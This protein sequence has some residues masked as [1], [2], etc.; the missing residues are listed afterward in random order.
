MR[1]TTREIDHSE[2]DRL[3]VAHVG[4]VK[5]LAHRLAQRLPP[6]VEIPDLISIGVLGLMDAAGRY[7]AVARRAVR[8]VRA[9]PRAGRDAR[10]AA[11]ARLGAAL[12]AQDAP[13]ARRRD[14]AAASR[15]APRADRGRDCRDAEHDAGRVRTVARAASHA[16]ARRRPAARRR[17]R[18]EAPGSSICAS[19]RTRGPKCGCSARS[20]ASTWRAPSRSCP[21]R[22]RHILAI[23]YQQEMTLAEI[24]AGH[25]RR[26][27]A[28]VAAP[29][30]GDLAPAHHAARDARRIR[31]RRRKW[32]R[33]LSQDE[34]D[35]LL[36]SVAVERRPAAAVPG[37]A[38]T[39]SSPTTSGG[40]I[41]RPEEQIRSLH[42]LHDRFA[43]NVSTV[44]LGVSC[45]TS[46]RSA[47]V[48][49]EQFTYSEFL[50]SLPDPTAFYA[51]ALQPIEGSRHSSSTRR[52]PSR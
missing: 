49:V 1:M 43:R 25:R 28:R 50:M 26:R 33:I 3:V 13:R 38:A 23:Y 20:C 51:V 18:G 45:A 31:R 30:A 8:R 17:R 32:A 48:S 52:S 19:I 29:V 35:A 40:R 24:G 5:A 7:R 27:I 11:R 47:I 37:R 9:P 22:E 34:I 4:L 41:A 15:A 2:R 46:P 21:P 12:A 42:F 44:A 14:R 6:Q 39:P 10:R 36:G 16:G